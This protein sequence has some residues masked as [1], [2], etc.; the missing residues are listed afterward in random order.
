MNECPNTFISNK[1]HKQMSEYNRFKN[2]T[3]VVIDILMENCINIWGKYIRIFKYI[4]HTLVYMA[5]KFGRC[6]YLMD[7]C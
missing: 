1:L 6:A 5:D 4:R 2:L 7:G 3:N